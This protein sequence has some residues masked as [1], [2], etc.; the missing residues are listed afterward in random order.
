MDLTTITI[1]SLLPVSRAVTV[2]T[3]VLATSTVRMSAKVRLLVLDMVL[4][5]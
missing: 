2:V 3:V 1:Q 5:R 4:Y